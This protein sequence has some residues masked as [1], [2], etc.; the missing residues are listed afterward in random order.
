MTVVELPALPGLT[1][2]ESAEPGV[3]SELVGT[4]AR[5]RWSA[6]ALA[7]LVEAESG[8]QPAKGLLRGGKGTAKEQIRRVVEPRINAGLR[9]NVPDETWR[10]YAA[11]L[12]FDGMAPKDVSLVP[13]DSVVELA[14]GEASLWE[15]F[16]ESSPRG[17]SRL[18]DYWAATGQPFPGTETPWSAAFVSWVVRH[19]NLPSRALV[20]SGGHIYYAREAYRNR[21]TVG[22]YGAFRPDELEAIEP[23]DIIVSKRPGAAEELTFSDIE[24]PTA[25]PFVPAHGDVVVEANGKNLRVVGGNVQ[26]AVTERNV[27][28]ASPNIVAVL[29]YQAPSGIVR[30]TGAELERRLLAVQAT[31]R[32]VL[33][34][35]LTSEA[36]ASGGSSSSPLKGLAFLAV[37]FGG[38]FVAKKVIR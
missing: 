2:R 17:E 7:L 31:S 29:R 38:A 1:A 4:A 28:A 22:R 25:A 35:P 16:D 23:G 19:S 13:L 33:R 8:W 26:N 27:S 9:S 5:H 11:A 30:L 21:G 36:V 20:P 6:P 18:R 14:R 34:V 3:L 32:G 15:D 10:Y 37:L 24:A 12:G